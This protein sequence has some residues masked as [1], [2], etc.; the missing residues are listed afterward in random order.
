MENH[1]SP[2]H[3]KANEYM[4]TVKSFKKY[5]G[6]IIHSKMILLIIKDY[7]LFFS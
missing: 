1:L 5:I 6:N 2:D 3:C 7:S 4:T